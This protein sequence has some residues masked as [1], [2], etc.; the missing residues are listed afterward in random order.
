M[1]GRRK[2]GGLGE[3]GVDI[4]GYETAAS[5]TLAPTE[6]FLFDTLVWRPTLLSRNGVSYITVRRWRNSVKEFQIEALRQLKKA[7]STG[8]VA[9]C[10]RD[11]VAGLDGMIAGNLYA[12]VVPVPCSRSAPDACLSVLLAEKLAAR[13]RLTMIEA[14]A[15]E[16][17]DGASHPRKNADRPAMRLVEP[18]P[19]PCLLVDDVASSGRHLEEGARLLRETA[20]AILAVAWIGGGA[21]DSAE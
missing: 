14:L 7:P 8:F 3:A 4:R 6:A 15:I 16:R 9:A 11:V 2:P 13:L 20:P 12:H 21:V 19:G 10:A 1:P 5:Q 18:V 17:A